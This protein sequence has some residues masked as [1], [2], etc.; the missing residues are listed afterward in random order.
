MNWIPRFAAGCVFGVI[1]AA[2]I[3]TFCESRGVRRLESAQVTPAEEAGGTHRKG[4]RQDGSKLS[5][6]AKAESSRS[7]KPSVG[8]I[9]ALPEIHACQ[10]QLKALNSRMA[11]CRADLEHESWNPRALFGIEVRDEDWARNQ[12]F[13]LMTRIMNA[14]G[15]AK[16]RISL[17]CRSACCQLS[18]NR[19]DAEKVLQDVAELG[20]GS[21]M[22][23]DQ[24][25]KAWNCYKRAERDKTK[26]VDREAD[27]QAVLDAAAADLEDC[28]KG[29]DAAVELK[30]KLRLD[31]FGQIAGTNSRAEPM[32][33]SAACIERA[34]LRH[35]SFG[36][37]SSKSSIIFLV[38]LKPL[39]A[40]Q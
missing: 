18:L 6:Q 8:V 16:E 27:R 28:R 30:L 40:A 32:G 19:F 22:M 11:R 4:G 26:G 25:G 29:L 34:L 13:Q 2:G 24:G 38:R 21:T 14:S 3:M 36:P 23:N 17:E 12:E 37:A 33:E 39:H 31:K 9:A 5:E 15:L 1:A 10:Q 20:F 7:S 35:A